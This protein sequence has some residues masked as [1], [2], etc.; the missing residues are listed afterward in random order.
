MQPPSPLLIPGIFSHTL[1]SPHTLP[2][3]PL[4]LSFVNAARALLDVRQHRL[5][6]RTY[7]EACQRSRDHPVMGKCRVRSR[8]GVMP[9]LNCQLKLAHNL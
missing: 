2:I 3:S 4:T 1:S 6:L 5:L 8:L 7:D 9:T